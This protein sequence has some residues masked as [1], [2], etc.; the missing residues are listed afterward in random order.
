MNRNFLFMEEHTLAGF[1][2]LTVSYSFS[3]V[4]SGTD[5]LFL[6][7]IRKEIKGVHLGIQLFRLSLTP[8]SKDSRKYFLLPCITYPLCFSFYADPPNTSSGN[9]RN[10]QK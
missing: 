7:H 5:S 10:F 2:A 6:T 9:I 8:H 4:L 3:K 1:C